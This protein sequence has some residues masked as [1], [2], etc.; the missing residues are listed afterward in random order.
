MAFLHPDDVKQVKRLKRLK[1]FQ[2]FTKAELNSLT[3]NGGSAFVCGDGDIDAYDYHASAVDRPHHQACYGGPL[4]LA[5]SYKDFSHL[6]AE[7]MLRNMK[8]GMRLKKTKSVFLYFHYPCAAALMVGYTLDQV[9]GL[10][11]EAISRLKNEDGLDP[12]KIYAFFHF[13]WEGKNGRVIQ[14]TYR[15][16]G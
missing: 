8:I 3:K 7:G 13:K 4:I 1:V 16:I 14:K 5:H 12:E 9:L 6:F 10:A 11:H 15:L 2:S